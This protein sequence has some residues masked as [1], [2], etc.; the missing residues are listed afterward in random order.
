M[1]V[2]TSPAAILKLAEHGLGLGYKEEAYSMLLAIAAE[3]EAQAKQ[4]PFAWATKS[5]IA[6]FAESGVGALT[7]YK[8]HC[9]PAK[10]GQSAPL[11]L[12]PQPAEEKE[13]NKCPRQSGECRA[14]F[15][16]GRGDEPDSVRCWYMRDNHTFRA[17]PLDVEAALAVM[18]EERDAGQTFGMLCGSPDGVVPPPVHAR[19]AAEWMAFEAQAR[20]WLDKAVAA[21]SKMV[22]PTDV[23]MPEP[24]CD[25]GALMEA[26]LR[27]IAKRFCHIYW[28]AG[29]PGCPE[30]IKAPNGELFK[31]RCKKCGE[32]NP[33][34]KWCAVEAPPAPADV[35]LSPAE[36]QVLREAVRDSVEVVHEGFVLADVPLP[37][38]YDH[39]H[40]WD[41][42]LYV[43]RDLDSAPKNGRPP[44][45][46]IPVFTSKQF[47]LGREAYAN[48]KVAA[49]RERI[50]SAVNRLTMLAENCEND[51]PEVDTAR[52]SLACTILAAIAGYEA[53]P[54]VGAQS[55]LFEADKKGTT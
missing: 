31:L 33:K 44:N 24:R 4:E 35:P 23:P 51:G 41:T 15:F 37:E 53:P 48:A 38:P 47:L 50:K 45:R 39:I 8:K 17:L 55:G 36:H 46:S 11:Y 10:E 3:K 20:P 42:P 28:G 13:S 19:T 49:E 52:K 30:D 26:G 12:A 34:L 1:S 40:E 7:A 29:E 5:G 18:R 2:D 27:A 6:R 22:A 21:A 54:Q 25:A 43:E 16:D 14:K 9:I 32:D